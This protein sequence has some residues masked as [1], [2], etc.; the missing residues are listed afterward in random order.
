[1]LLVDYYNKRDADLFGIPFAIIKA[2]EYGLT[3]SSKQN[4]TSTKLLFK[5]S[6]H[7]ILKVLKLEF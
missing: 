5:F 2:Y 7:F 1:M 3:S 4:N 6:V